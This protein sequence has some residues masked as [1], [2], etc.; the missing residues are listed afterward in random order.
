MQRSRRECLDDLLEFVG[1][2]PADTKARN[3]AEKLFNLAVERIWG[4]HAWTDFQSPAPYR[5]TLVVNQRK[6]ALPDYFGRLGP[7]GIRNLTR[8]GPPINPIQPHQLPD[9]AETDNEQPG[10][11]RAVVFAGTVGVQVQP[12]SSGEALEVV[13]DDAADVDIEVTVEGD[14]T[15]GQWTRRR[16]TLNGTTPVAV[17]TWSYVDG[18]GKAYR[19]GTTPATELT[20]SRGI[21]TLR[22]S[23][24]GAT[25]QTLFAEESAHEHKVISVY[26]K[27]DAAD[28]LAI[29]VIRRPKRMLYDAD[30]TPAD[31]WPA[32]FEEMHIRW[33]VQGGD[34]S[35][36]AAAMMPRPALKQLIENDN[37]TKM[38]IQRRGF[39]GHAIV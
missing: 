18:F 1:E 2:S 13:S 12:V 34:L 26:P 9:D 6:Y 35:E 29:P 33:Q 20:S 14:N 31:W 27:P 30:P 17:G 19:F 37:L 5:L 10:K 38:Q 21:V 22:K 8:M 24:A 39:G 15:S 4:A 32:L 23:P 7:G 16:V 11:P 25:L 36:Q 3:I 28:V